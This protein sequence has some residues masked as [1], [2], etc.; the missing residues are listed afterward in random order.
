VTRCQLEMARLATLLPL[1]VATACAD[2]S[3]GAALNACHLQH[4]MQSAAQQAEVVPE[5]MRAKS[6]ALAPGCSVPADLDDWAWQVAPAGY[7]Y[8]RCYQPVG[9]KAWVA[10]AL[11]PM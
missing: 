8:E 10:T 3:R 7:D 2:Q 9:T 6:Y 1:L 5:C 11:S 4:Y